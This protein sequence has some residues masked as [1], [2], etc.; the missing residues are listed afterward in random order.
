MSIC[1]R[2]HTYRLDLVQESQPSA[3]ERHVDSW[4]R[5]GKDGRWTRIHRSARRALF[6]PFKV[7]GGPSTK[8]PLKKIRI[9]RGKY[10]NSGKTFKIID[11]W[12]VRANAHRL[13]ESAWLGTTDFREASEFVDDDSDEETEEP[14]ISPGLAERESPSGGTSDEPQ[15]KQQTE[16]E[17]FELSPAKPNYFELSPAK[18]NYSAAQSDLLVAAPKGSDKED[19]RQPAQSNEQGRLDAR[20]NSFVFVASSPSTSW[21]EG[22]SSRGS[23]RETPLRFCER[24]VGLID[25]RPSGTEGLTSQ[26]RAATAA[27]RQDSRGN[28]CRGAPPLSQSNS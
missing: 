11:D 2:L 18:S 15:K 17:Y 4:G 21:R 5:E 9:T 23:T 1:V 20:N 6:T 8:T 27:R 26:T 12:T 7:A 22:P 14:A 25:Q 28:A 16:T 3:A 19:L 10:L 13:L 24:S